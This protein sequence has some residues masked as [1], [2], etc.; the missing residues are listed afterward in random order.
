MFWRNCRHIGK[1]CSAN[2]TGPTAHRRDQE[3]QI[4]DGK[5]RRNEIQKLP[6]PLACETGSGTRPRDCVNGYRGSQI[7]FSKTAPV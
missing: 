2:E 1:V 5:T 3:K 7:K 6:E 4:A